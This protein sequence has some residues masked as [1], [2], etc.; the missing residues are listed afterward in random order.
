MNPYGPSRS[1]LWFRLAV[2]LG[3]LVLVAVAVVVKGF[4]SPGWVEAVGVGG[5]FFGL[6]ALWSAWKLFGKT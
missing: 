3:G 4:S 2:S 5:V 1:E 6:S